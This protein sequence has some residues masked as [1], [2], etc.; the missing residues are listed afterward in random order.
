LHDRLAEV[1]AR[2]LSRAVPL[3]LAGKA[4]R[5][6]QDPG[7]ATY[8]GKLNREDGHLSWSDP[9]DLL[10]RLIRAYDP[11]PG[12]FTGTPAGKLKIFP[13]VRVLPEN[14]PASLPGTILTA[15]ADGLVVACGKGAISVINIQ[16]EGGKRQDIGAFLRGHGAV[17]LPG[18]VLS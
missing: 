14:N 7:L 16:L 11:W 17:L 15:A 6:P 3:L 9:A 18:Q 12:T 4:P 8:Q 1:A 2:A 10:E 13:P 5:T